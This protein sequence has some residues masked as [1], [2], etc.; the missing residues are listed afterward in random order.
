MTVT[1][2]LQQLHTSRVYVARDHTT[3][4]LLL[5]LEKCGHV[6]RKNNGWIITQSG[7]EEINYEYGTSRKSL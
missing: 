6:E 7:K 4:N 3:L 5:V 2:L 1:E